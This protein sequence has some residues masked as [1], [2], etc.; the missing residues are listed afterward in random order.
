MQIAQFFPIL[1]SL[2]RL[3]AFPMM[4]CVFSHSGIVIFYHFVLGMHIISQQLASGP[5]VL[6]VRT[7][8]ESF[9]CLYF[10]PFFPLL[11]CLFIY[12]HFNV[13]ALKDG[14]HFLRKR[15]IKL[16]IHNSKHINCLEKQKK[17]TIGF[18]RINGN[19]HFTLTLD[20]KPEG[21]K[22]KRLSDNQ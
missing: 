21:I 15:K 16:K 3:L 22:S 2:S 20:T 1:Y 19:L 5:L 17:H 8:T 11:L 12:Q 9:S 13:C 4:L 14:I 7:L 18:N 10:L 6:A